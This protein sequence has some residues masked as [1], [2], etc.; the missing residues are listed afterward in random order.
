M[1]RLFGWA[2]PMLFTGLVPGSM[3]IDRLG[4]RECPRR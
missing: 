2:L 1:M 4:Y 3:I